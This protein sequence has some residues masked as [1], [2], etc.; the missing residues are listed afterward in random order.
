[1]KNIYCILVIM[2]SLAYISCTDVISIDIEGSEGDLVVDGWI[3]NRNQAQV[4][5]LSLSQEY[6]DN[7]NPPVAQGATVTVVNRTKGINYDFIDINDNGFYT[8]NPTGTI[9]SLGD[10]QD[11]LL[12]TIDYNGDQY[13]SSTQIQRV[14]VIDSITQEYRENEVF[15]DDGIYTQF[16]ARDFEGTGDSYWIKSYKNGEYLK[17]ANELN[18]A[19]DAGFDAGSQIDGIIFITPIREFINEK[20]DDGLDVPWEVGD[21]LTVEIHSLTT[22]AF[23][24]LEI[25]RDQIN[26]GDNGIF[27]LPLANVRTNITNAQEKRVL[28]FFNVAAVSSASKVIE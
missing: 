1:M 25:T 13:Q 16:F 2:S 21:S 8:W 10:P 24:F 12:L 7:T 11:Q 15:L 23:N 3:D 4:I 6:F 18:I 17:D 14:P 5:R 26:N 27:A 19:F 28:G 22:D 20:D 9:Q